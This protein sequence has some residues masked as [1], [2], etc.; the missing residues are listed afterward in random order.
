MHHAAHRGLDRR[1]RGAAPADMPDGAVLQPSGQRGVPRMIGRRFALVGGAALLARRT[2]AA[3]PRRESLAF[4]LVRHG[5]EIGTHTL[6][7][8]PDG[9]A[10]TVRIAVDAVVTLR[11]DSDRAVPPPGGGV[12]AGGDAG[13]PDRADRQE[14]RARLGQCATHGRGIG[15]RRQPDGAVRRARTRRSPPRIGTSGC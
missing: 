15:G 8:E 6:S 11:L 14:R 3:R 5:D 12:L 10:L 1:E 2:A 9:E 7:F 4:R 13:R